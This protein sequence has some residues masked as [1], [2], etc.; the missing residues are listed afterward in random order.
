M[1]LIHDQVTVFTD[2]IAN[3]AFTHE[4]LNQGHIQQSR[5]LFSSAADPADCFGWTVEE[6]RQSFHPLFQQLSSVDEYQRAH[7]AL[8]NQPGGDHGLTESGGGR[9]HAGVVGQ[10]CRRRRLLFRPQITVKHQ[11]QWFASESFVTD[12]RL[13]FCVGQQLQHVRETTAGQ[14]DVAR[15]ILRAGDDA[16]F[17]VR[18]QSHGLRSIELRI[19]KRR[20]TD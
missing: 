6:C 16:R 14:T 15:M 13:N 4:A 7:S 2:Q 17:I 11:R 8:R 18:W 10:Q 19:L 20:Q 5:R 9:Q 12:H 3:D 1:T